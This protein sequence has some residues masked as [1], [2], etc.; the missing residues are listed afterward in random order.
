MILK[1]IFAE[2]ISP[3]TKFPGIGLFP[4]GPPVKGANMIPMLPSISKGSNDVPLNT[5]E[6]D[7]GGVLGTSHQ[8]DEQMDSS[9]FVSFYKGLIM[10]SVFI[11]AVV[12]V[13]VVILSFFYRGSPFSGSKKSTTQA[14]LNGKNQQRPVHDSWESAI[15][16]NHNHRTR[17]QVFSLRMFATMHNWFNRKKRLFHARRRRHSNRLPNQLKSR[18]MLYYNNG[19]AASANG[20]SA[21]HWPVG[22]NQPSLTD[23]EIMTSL[24][25]VQKNRLPLVSLV[26]NP[27]Y[28]SEAEQHLLENS[29]NAYV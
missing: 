1:I 8:T 13:G 2:I 9:T 3:V 12:V 16:T 19:R 23:Q 17:D 24:I 14:G 22:N 10:N 7:D 5:E 27:N 18:A 29:G 6:I 28:F 11:V 21:T 26:S 20:N 15:D 25:N 4:K